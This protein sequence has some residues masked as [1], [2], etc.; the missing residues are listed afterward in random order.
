MNRIILSVVVGLGTMTLFAADPAANEP[1]KKSVKKSY[2][3]LTPQEKA[4]RIQ[5]GR[6]KRAARHG[7]LLYIENSQRGKIVF[8]NGQKC[9][10]KE[11]IEGVATDVRL[12]DDL[13]VE[14]VDDSGEHI[15]PKTAAAKKKAL[16]AD[17]AIFLTECDTCDN[18]MLTAPEGA[19][20][21]VNAAAICKGA[22]ND[23]FKRTRM[24]KMVQRGYY[25]A[26]GAMN[27][28]YP[29]SLMGAVRNLDDLDKLTAEPP[30]DVVDRTLTSLEKAGVTPL[31]YTTYKKACQQGWAP[32]PTNELQ[33]AIW[34]EIHTPPSKPMKITFDKGKQKPV[35]K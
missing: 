19:W 32:A 18:L 28:Q 20:A 9:V 7:G 31:T 17:V 33:K 12:R 6:E 3:Q 26:A 22:M 13:K 8:V 1:A 15:S 24:I 29:N 16:G 34:N 10:P 30:M 27:S 35:V 21:I 5:R 2:D 11:V 4:E 23:A 25:C 14:V